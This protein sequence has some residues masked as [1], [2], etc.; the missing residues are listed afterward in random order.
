MTWKLLKLGSV[1]ELRN[2]FAF[3]SKLFKEKGLPILRISNIQNQHIDNRR[4]VYFDANDYKIDFKKYEV[5]NGDLLI[6]MS[7]ATTGKIGFNESQI[8]YYLNQR[9]GKLVPNKDLDKKYLYYILLSKI[10]ENLSISRGTAQPNLSSE[11]IKNIE[12]SLPPIHEQQHL[13]TKLDTI[14][15]ELDKLIKIIKTQ[16]IDVKK[17]FD[18]NLLKKFC[19]KSYKEYE[20]GAICKI[21]GGSQPPKSNFE[22]KSKN[23]N[24][25]FIQIRDYKNDNNIVY[26][27]RE[28][29][30][31]FCNK[32]DVM[33]GRYGPPIFQILRGIEGAYNV[34]LMKAVPKKE[35]LNDYLFYF[36]KNKKIQDYI[37]KKSV[38][39]AGQSGVNKQALE[40]YKINLPPIEEQKKIINNIRISE[41]ET[42]KLDVL[43]KKKIKLNIELKSIILKNLITNNK[44]A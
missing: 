42:I 10:E 8:T 41:E 2:G 38:R 27:P 19:N 20:L 43:L 11:Q 14:F 17:F 21:I 35:I 22:Y 28:K 7:G 39:A 15:D 5:N 24:I 23:T 25:R 37:I 12:I 18:E 33:I 16:R 34:A 36:L 26:I 4:P 3:K 44:A 31:R 6:A 1:C 29:A 40:P 13:V 32:A 30:K 9:V